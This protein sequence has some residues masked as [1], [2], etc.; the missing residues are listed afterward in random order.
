MPT[1]ILPDDD[2]DDWS[3][4]AAAGTVDSATDRATVDRKPIEPSSRIDNA[5]VGWGKPGGAIPLSIFGEE[6]TD[7]GEA[8]DDPGVAVDGSEEVRRGDVK[9]VDVKDL[10]ANLYGLDGMTSSTSLPGTGL[11]FV[12]NGKVGGPVSEIGCGGDEVVDEDDEWEFRAAPEETA[13]GIPKFDTKGI[14]QGGSNLISSGSFISWDVL[15]FKA[16]GHQEFNLFVPDSNGHVLNS[17]TKEEDGD[18]DDGWEFQDARLES[19]YKSNMNNG[20]GYP[21][22]YEDREVVISSK[23]S[24]G[25]IS[26][27]SGFRPV[28]DSSVNGLRLDV[29]QTNAYDDSDWEFHASGTESLYRVESSEANKNSWETSK[30][31]VGPFD[32]NKGP[33][34][35][36][37]VA[38]S[39]NLE[40]FTSV[41]LSLDSHSNLSG[42]DSNHGRDVNSVTQKALGDEFWEFKHVVPGNGLID[43]DKLEDISNDSEAG[44]TQDIVSGEN[45]QVSG[46]ATSETP[47]K[48]EKNKPSWD[49]KEALPLSLFGDEE[50]ENSYNLPIQNDLIIRE[51]DF[52][53]KDDQEMRVK[54][55][56]DTSITDL[57]ASLYSQPLP[58]P[59]MMVHE[60]T[61]GGLDS[62][63]AGSEQVVVA[64][65]DDFDDWD[66]H[67]ASVDISGGAPSLD[68]NTQQFT[69]SE[70]SS[71]LVSPETLCWKENPENTDICWGLS[72][73]SSQANNV[74]Q[75]DISPMVPQNPSTRVEL[76]D[77]VGFYDSLESELRVA[78]SHH[79]SN[80]EIHEDAK[81]KLHNE[82]FQ[83]LYNE[84]HTGE[85][86][87]EIP[88]I[89]RSQSNINIDALLQALQGPK[90]QVLETEYSL[91]SRLIMAKK[92]VKSLA[93]LLQHVASVLRLFR[94]GTEEEHNRYVSTWSKMI[95]ACSKELKHGA[96]LW[97]KCLE[98]DFQAQILSKPEGKQFILS[99]GEIYRVVE[100]L[101][102]SAR[103]YKPWLI[104]SADFFGITAMLHEC[105]SDWSGS[106]LENALRSISDPLEFQYEGSVEA[107]VESIEQ[108]R[109][110]DTSV[111]EEMIFASEDPLCRLSLLIP[112]VV[113]GMKMVSWNGEQ[114][115]LKLINLWANLVISEP[116]ELPQ[117]YLRTD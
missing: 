54:T 79:L 99:L 58:N 102:V 39:E 93:E 13:N 28:S 15:N 40:G 7:D 101:G 24:N 19:H 117:I 52:M 14:A 33:H 21:I 59:S 3:D 114:Y 96:T 11:E 53:V 9:Q 113:P 48:H 69:S 61:Q 46:N 90:F 34:G 1:A 85:L 36:L 62:A 95:T 116:P 64:E 74:E 60:I 38:A 81:L 4:F 30:A 50:L 109:K 6:E 32:S 71:I 100:V 92:D 87:S 66:F 22:K 49:T 70:F 43:Q 112:G 83:D 18:D 82:E 115:F 31:V 110:L 84:L 107:I 65:E 23:T 45:L 86:V 57:I 91:S 97:R 27:F 41:N 51:D 44:K 47:S 108:V 56:R 29:A 12:A 35:D 37:F 5:P 76:R 16:N 94:L 55:T 106:G 17:P 2:D 75:R 88:S 105:A 73:M 103:F 77:L 89:S 72:D 98:H 8:G 80:D 25:V 42:L 26:D 20:V 111:L 104:S 10:I 78:V 67:G 68:E 63:T